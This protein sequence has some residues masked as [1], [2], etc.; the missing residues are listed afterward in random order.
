VYWGRFFVHRLKPWDFK[1]VDPSSLP[2]SPAPPRRPEENLLIGGLSAAFVKVDTLQPLMGQISKAMPWL[3][4]PLSPAVKALF[5]M[6]N[7]TMSFKDQREFLEIAKTAKTFVAAPD[8][9]RPP[10]ANSLS[11]SV[12]DWEIRSLQTRSSS[13]PAIES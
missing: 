10:F 13:R 6:G 12:L 2:V 8:E 7:G 11:N 3:Q 5:W 9:R 1:R 4:L